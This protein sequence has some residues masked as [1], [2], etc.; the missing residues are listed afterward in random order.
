M[1]L[2][3]FVDAFFQDALLDNPAGACLILQALAHR[4]VNDPSRLFERITVGE[5][6][7]ELAKE[8][9]A[10]LLRQKTE[11]ALEQTL[12]FGGD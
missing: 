2:N 4:H 6:L 10:T 7:L 5:V 9:F 12:A 1:W 8:G 11:E 3:A